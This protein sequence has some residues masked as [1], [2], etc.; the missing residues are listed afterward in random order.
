MHFLTIRQRD[1]RMLAQKIMKRRRASF[2]SSWNNE[3]QSLN[4]VTFESK[5][6]LNRA[7]A[8]DLCPRGKLL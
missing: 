5:H 1:L 6:R 2:L 4:F 7:F 8:V 3:I